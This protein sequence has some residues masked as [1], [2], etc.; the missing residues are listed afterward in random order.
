MKEEDGVRVG[1]MATVTVT[2]AR[3]NFSSD[4]C[5]Y[6]TYLFS[7]LNQACTWFLEIVPVRMSV[8][9]FVKS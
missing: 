9:V 3:I 7:F 5:I 4:L 6:L 8:C 1:V 2:T